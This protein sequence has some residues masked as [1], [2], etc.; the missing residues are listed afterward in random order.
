MPPSVGKYDC[1]I[2]GV[3]KNIL[4]VS[5]ALLMD[6]TSMHDNTDP[7][8]LESDIKF[9]QDAYILPL[10]GTNLYLKLQTLL[11]DDSNMGQTDAVNYKSLLDNYIIDALINYTLAELPTSI[12]FQFWNKGVMQKSGEDAS[13][14]SMDELITI[15][16]KYKKRAEFYANR[17]RTFLMS[18]TQDI[19]PEYF[20]FGNTYEAINPERRAFTSPIFLGPEKGDHCNEIWGPYKP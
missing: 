16:D 9:A 20:L 3:S 13:P 14:A 17:C 5:A 10:L 15:A 18:S 7:K 19:F 11:N 1:K 2:K 4:F 8:L 6:R 12:S